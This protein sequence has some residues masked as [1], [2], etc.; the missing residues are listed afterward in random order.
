VLGQEVAVGAPGWDAGLGGEGE[1]RILSGGA[2]LVDFGD[3]PSNVPGAELGTALATIG[4]LDKFPSRGVLV[5]AP[6]WRDA[7]M[8]LLYDLSLVHGGQTPSPTFQFSGAPVGSRF[9]QSLAGNV[10]VD[11]DGVDD[12]L[13]GAPGFG[14]DQGLVAVGRVYVFFG[15]L[16]TGMF[17]DA[18]ITDAG[19]S[20]PGDAG[21]SD[22]GL[23]DA[24][25]PD[26]GIRPDAGEEGDAG[27]QADAGFNVPP[28]TDGGSADASPLDFRTQACGCGVTGPGLLLPLLL[29]PAR[30]RMR[31][32]GYI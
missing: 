22:A 16:R 30:R 32:F 4:S 23:T 13:I 7:G 5:G 2:P 11:G 1:F 17:G 25:V 29:V 15:P 26:A 12:I 19:L 20:G 14:Q 8:A 21:A 3:F 18:G 24:G 9:G 10:D 28:R 6:G 31:R 27:E